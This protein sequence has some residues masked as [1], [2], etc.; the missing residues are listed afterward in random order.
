MKAKYGKVDNIEFFVPNIANTLKGSSNESLIFFGRSHYEQRYNVVLGVG[1]VRMIKTSEK[2]DLVKIN[3]GRR[4]SRLIIV[5]DNHARRQI[6]TLTKG[7]LAWFYGYY[8][9]F[10]NEKGELESVLYAKGFQGWYVPKVMDIRKI[11]SDLPQELDESEQET[12]QQMINDLF[13]KE[14]K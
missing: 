1:R 4:Y 5:K 9:T 13:E 6:Y 2:F 3:F 14:N 8:A 7:Q 12:M 11:D 10:K